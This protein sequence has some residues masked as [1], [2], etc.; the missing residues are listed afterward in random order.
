MKLPYKN[1]PPHEES[2]PPPERLFD[3][4]DGF[5]GAIVGGEIFVKECVRGTVVSKSRTIPYRRGVVNG[6]Q[7]FYYLLKSDKAP[8]DSELIPSTW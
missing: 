6:E 1:D 3:E 7:V 5:G 8:P 2:K 4:F